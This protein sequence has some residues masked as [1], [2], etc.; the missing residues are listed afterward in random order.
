MHAQVWV[1]SQQSN[2]L[3]QQLN[4][5]KTC[6]ITVRSMYNVHTQEVKIIKRLYSM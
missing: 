4:D 1:N 5:N 6:K 2:V 3:I